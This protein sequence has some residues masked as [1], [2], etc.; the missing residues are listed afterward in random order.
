MFN[1]WR[2]YSLFHPKKDGRYLCVLK[3]ESRK[4]M[5][6]NYSTAK[7]EWS[8]LER[9]SVFDGYKV[10]KQCRAAIEDNRMYT[11]DICGYTD[12]LAW[13]RLPK[14]CRWGRTRK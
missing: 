9:Q 8:N 14:K 13:K 11:D 10:Y 12:I 7:K 2:S 4:I 1:F 5:I 3:D 6:L